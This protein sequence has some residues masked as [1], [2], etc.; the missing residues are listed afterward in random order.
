MKMTQPDSDITQHQELRAEVRATLSE[1]SAEGVFEPC[2]DGWSRAWDQDFSRRL[3]GRGWMAMTIPSEFGGPGRTPIE[4]FIVAE[5]LL[6]AGA[7]VSA[8]WVAE[9]QITPLLLRLGTDE[10][11]AR[12]LPAI[13]R[14]E[15]TFAI[16]LS[17]PGSGSDLASVRTS[18]RREDDHWL[19]TGQKVWTTNGHRADRMVTLCRTDPASATR[20]E[21][22]SQLMVDLKAPGVEI[23]TIPA[24]GGDNDFCE[25]FFTD[26]VVPDADV[27]GVVGNGW[28]QVLG[29]LES[30]RSGPDRYM[31]T[32]PLLSRW[33]AASHDD[34]A[35]VAGRM[36]AD[37]VALREMSMAIAQNLA[38]GRPIG[39]AATLCKD[40]GT[41]F[42]QRSVDQIRDR[43]ARHPD[44]ADER[45][46]EMLD[47]M[48]LAAPTITLRG[49]TTEILRGMSARAL[50]A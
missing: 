22:L 24:M 43:A 4:R 9:R 17:E 48:T 5:E 34:D 15:L 26:V 45:L 44:T 29:E 12:L 10:Q 40:A 38:A 8:H 1:W 42:E 6:A 7:P 32:F 3:A 19:I 18:A 47:D 50:M 30:E 13:A 23:R 28:Q 2:C 35:E 37:F 36:V 11:R 39:T 21:G 20:H 33:L 49:G 25:I 27:F 16:G 46:Q 41:R 31:S 14:A